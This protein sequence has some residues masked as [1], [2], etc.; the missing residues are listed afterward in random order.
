LHK[1]PA[2]AG[3]TTIPL[4]LD[5]YGTVFVVFR[6]AAPA[7]EWQEPEAKEAPLPDLDQAL[8]HNW[9]VNFPP[10]RGAP[11]TLQLDNLASWSDNSNVGVKYFSGTATYTKTIDIPDAALTP[12]AHL[13]LDLGDVKEVA[14][15]AVNGKYQGILWKAPYKLDLTGVLKPGSNQLVIA[16]T[17][18][19]VNRLIGDRQP[20]SLKKYAFADIQLYKADSPLL[21]SGL[22]GPVRISAVTQP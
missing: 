4:H 11:E 15:V 21:P 18:L 10:Y 7:T 16:V 3:R 6:K 14:E 1:T 2:A 9:I 17:N 22:L 20:W 8:N 5:P 12:G 19:W 13:W